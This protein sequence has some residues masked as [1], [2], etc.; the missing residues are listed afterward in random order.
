MKA[1]AYSYLSLVDGVTQR[2]TT[3]AECETRVKGKK[4]KFRKTVSMKD[5]KD[6]LNEW[7][8]SL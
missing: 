2:H 6:I 8:V 1:K 4:A 3:W 7:G 5:E